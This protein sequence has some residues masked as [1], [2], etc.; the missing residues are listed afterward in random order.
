[1]EK[2]KTILVHNDSAVIE[3][4]KTNI[5]NLDKVEVIATATDGKDALNKIT[6]LKPDIVFAKFELEDMNGMELLEKA[7]KKLYYDTPKFEYISSKLTLK[8]DNKKYDVDVDDEDEIEDSFVFVKE[9]GI[10]EIITKLKHYDKP[11]ISKD[12]VINI[13]NHV[14]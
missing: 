12:K 6:K 14:N 3:N 8:T 13:F 4:I 9:L 5:K 1:M 11:R 10:E 7:Y 2:I